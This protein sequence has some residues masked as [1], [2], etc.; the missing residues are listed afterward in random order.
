MRAAKLGEAHVHCRHANAHGG[1]LMLG[2]IKPFAYTFHMLRILMKIGASL[3][4]GLLTSYFALHWVSGHL[5]VLSA[6]ACSTEF[7]GRGLACR[8]AGAGVMLLAIPIAGVLV[9]GITMYFW[10]RRS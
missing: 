8:F 7:T 3:L 1:I 6:A 9:F 2:S 4:L 10:F 5:D